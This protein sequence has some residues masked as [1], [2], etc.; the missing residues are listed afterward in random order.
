MPRI[1]SWIL[2]SLCMGMIAVLSAGAQS[3]PTPTA[4]PASQCYPGPLPWQVVMEAD[5]PWEDGEGVAMP[6]VILDGGLYRMWYHVSSDGTS[7][8]GGKIAYAESVDGLSWSGKQLLLSSGNP[9][10]PERSLRRPVVLKVG[11]QY[12][13][14]NTQ[15]YLSSIDWSEFVTLRTSSDGLSWSAWQIVLAMT[16]KETWERDNFNVR[17]VFEEPGGGFRM[18]YSVRFRLSPTPDAYWA[19]ATSADGINWSNRQRLLGQDDAPLFAT[20]QAWYYAFDLTETGTY[21]CLYADGSGDLQFAE[22]SD[23]IHWDRGTGGYLGAVNLSTALASP[24]GGAYGGCV[25]RPPEGGEVLYFWPQQ[26]LYK[27][28]RATLT[29]PVEGWKEY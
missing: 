5:Q 20:L 6:W 13:M 8:A 7:S 25:V 2:G 28:A 17:A 11:S 18:F 16:G 23:G 3:T 29:T 1:A 10:G 21:R 22:S 12:R 14:Y 15:Y 4:T 9:A 24:P 26:T 19:T 27:I